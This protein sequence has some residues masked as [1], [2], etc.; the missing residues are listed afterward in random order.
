MV[1]L[2]DDRL[3]KYGNKFFNM[4]KYPGAIRIFYNVL[5]N[6][7]SEKIKLKAYI[8]L[9][10]SLRAKYEIELAEKMYKKAMHIAENLEDTEMIK[11]IDKRI[12]NIYIFKKERD[13]NPVQIGFF[14][15][16]IMKLLSFLGKTDWF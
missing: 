10:N 9:G 7:P 5:R 1:K 14:M 4:K 6:N 13:L 16:T 12:E 8:G 11:F 3:I 2:S 15:R